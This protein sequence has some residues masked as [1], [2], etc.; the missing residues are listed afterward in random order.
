MAD[1][2]KV[3]ADADPGGKLHGNRPLSGFALVAKRISSWTTNCLLSVLILVA[4]FTFARQVLDW[5]AADETA[6][7]APA[8]QLAMTE[9]LGDPARVHLLQFGEMPWV[10]VRE[11]FIGTREE[12]AIALRE[13]CSETVTGSP[14]LPDGKA[15]PAEQ[16]FLDSLAKRAPVSR[17]PDAVYLYEFDSSIP[18]VAAT[19]PVAPKQRRV[20]TWGMAVPVADEVWT[21][22]SL[23]PDRPNSVPISDLP[24]IRLPPECKKT[25][26]MQVSGGGAVVA[27]KGPAQPEVWKRSFDGR[28]GKHGWTA[29]G[30]WRRLGSTWHLRYVRQSE[31]NAEAV[32]VRFSPDGRGGMTGLLMIT[33]S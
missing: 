14:H 18:M 17:L 27:F 2:A 33:A 21:L 19:G 28:F 13:C 8:S 6:R 29:D 30:S 15:G 7:L 16:G 32:D 11:T 24:E 1:E 3:S 10:M 26:S 5:W 20:V 4:G 22:Y 31:S 9:G 25:V 12:A 23:H